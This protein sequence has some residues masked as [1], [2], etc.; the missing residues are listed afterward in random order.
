MSID[1]DII[2][3]QRLADEAARVVL[4]YFRQPVAVEAKADQSPVTPADRAVEAALRDI[5]AHDRPTDGVIGEE[6]GAERGTSGRLWV[7]DP[8]DGTRGFIAG[9]PLFGTLIALLEDGYPVLGVISA[10]AA[11]DRW[12]GWTSGAPQALLN[13]TPIRVRP[14]AS[15]GAAHA[16]STHPLL[17]SAAGHAAFQRVG[18]Q[19]AGMLFGGDCYNYGLLAAGCLDLV[20]EEGLKLHDWAALVPIIEAAGGCITDWQGHPLQPGGAGAVIACGDARVQ[21]EVLAQ[22]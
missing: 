5:L 7:L 12:V 22:I 8:I 15:L 9:R 16:A 2:L 1:S 18:R 14:C 21:A 13:G 20:I 3:A 19:V 4:P 17:F 6:Y 11:R 10:P